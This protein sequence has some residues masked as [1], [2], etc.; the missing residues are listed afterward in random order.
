MH[1]AMAW[2]ADPK[3][4]T[5]SVRNGCSVRTGPSASGAMLAGVLA[6]PFVRRLSE[7]AV[8]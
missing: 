3:V 6:T 7:A 5:L 4:R 2:A 1:W 8:Y